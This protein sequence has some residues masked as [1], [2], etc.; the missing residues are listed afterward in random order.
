METHNLGSI[1]PG[2]SEC[3]SS[4]RFNIPQQ[5]HME[6]GPRFKVSS[7]RPGKHKIDV[8]IHGLVV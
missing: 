7:E 5:G 6:T 4:A 8:A 3:V 2:V 1:N